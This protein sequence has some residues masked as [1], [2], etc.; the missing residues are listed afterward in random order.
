MTIEQEIL[1]ILISSSRAMF[2]TPDTSLS[3]LGLKPME[4]IEGQIRSSIDELHIN[5]EFSLSLRGDKTVVFS[6][7]IF[8]FSLPIDEIQNIQDLADELLQ[9][10]NED[11]AVVFEG[12]V[13]DIIADFGISNTA[14]SFESFFTKDNSWGY[15]KIDVSKFLHA[16][17]ERYGIQIER[18]AVT[19][20]YG[21]IEELCT[22]LTQRI[23]RVLELRK[24]QT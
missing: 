19:K 17:K 24:S 15:S 14:I 6:Q 13:Y 5:S 10:S 7:P 22:T 18:R 20:F 4:I 9:L 16:I 23:N 3:E 21:T 12:N 11:G 2:C 1:N 8:E